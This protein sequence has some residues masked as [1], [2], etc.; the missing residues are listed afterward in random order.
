MLT[1]VFLLALLMLG[2]LGGAAASHLQV[3]GK[4]INSDK[5][6]MSSNDGGHT[7]KKQPHQQ[8]EIRR[9]LDLESYNVLVTPRTNKISLPS[10]I[11]LY[12][13]TAKPLHLHGNMP[14]RFGRESVPGDDKSPNSPPN[15]PQRFG[16]SWG[17]IQL[18]TEGPNVRE[19]QN[20]VLPQ[21]FGRS[22]PYRRLLRTLVNEKLLNTGLHW[23]KDFDFTT[24]SEEVEVQEKSFRG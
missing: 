7:V 19:A 9:S 20:P 5:T 11:K 23:A 14:M 15:M 21:R 8:S 2:G 12:P 22:S 3:Y 1:A 17:A 10:I 16:R 13:P 18:F 24:S 4:S 6:L